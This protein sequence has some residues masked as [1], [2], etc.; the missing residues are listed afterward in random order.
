MQTSDRIKLKPHGG[1]IS[2]YAGDELTLRYTVLDRRVSSSKPDMGIVTMRWE[3]IDQHGTVK[4]EMTGVNLFK[5]RHPARTEAA[6][7]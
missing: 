7:P 4:T 5:V 2:V 3:A 6:A 1:R